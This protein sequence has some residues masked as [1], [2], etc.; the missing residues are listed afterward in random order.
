MSLWI[1]DLDSDV[2]WETGK[3][4]K[5]EATVTAPATAPGAPVS[6]HLTDIPSPFTKANK[7]QKRDISEKF[8]VCGAYDKRIWPASGSVVM[9]RQGCDRCGHLY[10]H[11]WA[12]LRYKPKYGS[13]ACHGRLEAE[14]VESDKEEAEE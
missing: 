5:R 3:R 13:W 9:R 7:F 6:Q 12:G 11:Q 14:E 8:D 10:H 2:S 1:W 4:R